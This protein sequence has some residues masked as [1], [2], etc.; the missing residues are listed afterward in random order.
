MSLHLST[1]QNT[2]DIA[3]SQSGPRK[4]PSRTFVT[5]CN[6]YLWITFPRD[7]VKFGPDTGPPT[8]FP[9]GDTR[10]RHRTTPLGW[11]RRSHP[12][13]VE[14]DRGRDSRNRR[15]DSQPT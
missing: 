4:L 15:N 12:V 5:T 10:S 11:D 9:V 6:N 13:G 2:S 1:G 3:R 8:V 14:W 7:R